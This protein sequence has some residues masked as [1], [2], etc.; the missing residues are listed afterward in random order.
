MSPFISSREYTYHTDVPAS[1]DEV[2][3][4]IQHPSGLAS[5]SPLHKSILPEE[6]ERDWYIVTERLP[7]LGRFE[8][9]ISFRA[10][11][12]HVDN[13]VAIEVE[14]GL[15]T[16]LKSQY[17]VEKADGKGGCILRESTIVE[18]PFPLMPYI[19]GTMAKA[20]VAVLNSVARKAGDGNL[21]SLSHA[22]DHWS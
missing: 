17:L 5:Q 19:Y 13:G 20:H 3:K 22:T 9:S 15:G 4:F 7:L 12:R 21:P 18:A 1:Y 10:S 11:I 14:A 16:V 2:L 6:K 8:S